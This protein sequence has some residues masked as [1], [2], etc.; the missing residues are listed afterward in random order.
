MKY[1]CTYQNYEIEPLKITDS[2]VLCPCPKLETF[3]SASALT[4]G[5]IPLSL[6]I[7]NMVD[8]LYTSTLTFYDVPNVFISSDN[9]ILTGQ[10]MV[11]NVTMTDKSFLIYEK[12]GC[13][14]DS[15]VN[16]LSSSVM[17]D[18]VLSCLLSCETGGQSTLQ[19]GFLYSLL[20]PYWL[21]LCVLHRSCKQNRL[22]D[23]LFHS[24]IIQ[25]KHHHHHR[26]SQLINKHNMPLMP[27]QY[28]A[29][30]CLES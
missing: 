15:G 27:G 22:Y 18:G 5:V 17:S 21:S 13:S 19:V 16:V 14:V 29:Y 23:T 24:V 26:R 25:S 11:V 4:L 28:H 7:G 12:V 9:N 1:I 10:T 2:T 30:R 20:V 3:T 8:P 6:I